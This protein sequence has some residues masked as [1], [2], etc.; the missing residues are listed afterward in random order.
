[1]ALAAF[2]AQ[3]VVSLYG[4][5]FG[6]GLGILV[7]TA[8]GFLGVSDIRRANGLKN[9][10]SLAIKGVAV[11][12]FIVVSR[13]VWRAAIILGVGALLGGYAAA[14]YGRR[15]DGS[16]MRWTVTGIG[17]ALAGLMFVKLAG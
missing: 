13:V 11:V 6:A 10:F 3:F 2:G 12:Y 17:I 16:T 15:L 8:L 1:M 7:L 14:Q 5:Y 9:L 4:G